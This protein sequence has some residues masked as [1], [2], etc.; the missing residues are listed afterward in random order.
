MISVRPAGGVLVWQNFKVA[1]FSDTIKMIN[2]KLC[3]MVV[4]TELYPFVPLSVTL[5]VSSF[6]HSYHFQLTWLYFKNTAGSNTL[7]GH[8]ISSSD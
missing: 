3:M 2:V 1:V 7:T 8:S 6:T 4:L 5:I